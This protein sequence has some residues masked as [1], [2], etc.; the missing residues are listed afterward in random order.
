MYLGKGQNK[1]PGTPIVKLKVPDARRVLL[2]GMPLPYF[3][4]GQGILHEKTLS[5][6]TI[7]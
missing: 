5:K 3:N 7:K 6:Q 4:I 1:A 2:K